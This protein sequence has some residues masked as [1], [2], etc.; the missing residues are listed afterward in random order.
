MLTVFNLF[1]RLKIKFLLSQFRRKDDLIYAVSAALFLLFVVGGLAGRSIQFGGLLSW[2]KTLDESTAYL[3]GKFITLTIFSL[4]VALS[5]VGGLQFTVPLEFRAVIRYPLS[6]VGFALLNVL[7]QLLDVGP[8]VFLPLLFLAELLIGAG[9]LFGLSLFLLCVVMFY[10]ILILIVSI[11]RLLI[12]CTTPTILRLITSLAFVFVLIVFTQNWVVLPSLMSPSGLS[13]LLRYLGFLPSSLLIDTLYY[14]KKGDVTNWMGAVLELL[15]ILL[16]C[17]F[18]YVYLLY[19]VGPELS[20]TGVRSAH[21]RRDKNIFYR[22]DLFLGKLLP[23]MGATINAFMS[24]DLIY[25]SRNRRLLIWS[26]IYYVGV[27]IFL[28]SPFSSYLKFLLMANF[29]IL[30]FMPLATNFFA[31]DTGIRRYFNAPISIRKIFVQK[32]AVTSSLMIIIALPSFFWAVTR[33]GLSLAEFLSVVIIFTYNL[34]IVSLLGNFFSIYYPKRVEFNR[35]VGLFN[36]LASL[37]VQFISLGLCEVPL[38]TLTVLL[39]TN[40]FVYLMSLMGLLM[41]AM[42]LYL[43]TLNGLLVEKAENAKELIIQ[44]LNSER[45]LYEQ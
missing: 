27:V 30:T 28:T 7:T 31:L 26:L 13:K 23:S 22:I 2:L 8:V 5:F 44:R 40:L 45:S 42:C 10:L 9:G 15:L 33:G 38:I 17:F 32:N 19:L 14:F 39:G 18:L 29:G 37:P 41:L 34:I 21:S 20:A 24:K 35:V 25:F 3:M 1:I 12:R 36:P 11:A 4:W 43:Y 16:G 6:L